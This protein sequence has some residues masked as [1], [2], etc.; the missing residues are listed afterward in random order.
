MSLSE[1]SLG[2]LTL[3]LSPEGARGQFSLSLFPFLSFDGED[4]R[5]VRRGTP[6]LEPGTLNLE[7]FSAARIKRVHH[8]ALVMRG[9][10]QVLVQRVSEH[11][12][13]H[14]RVAVVRAWSGPNH[15]G[16]VGRLIVAVTGD[17]FRLMN[18]AFSRH[19]A[20]ELPQCFICGPA[21]LVESD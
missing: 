10:T 1:P 11:A 19:P 20:I 15:M 4:Q 12:V 9:R 16:I 14:Q 13:R 6:N 8:L 5:R 7:L 2:T 18:I 17:S 3:T 21:R